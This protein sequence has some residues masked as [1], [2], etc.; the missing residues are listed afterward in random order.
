MI[1]NNFFL[2]LFEPANLFVFDFADARGGGTSLC[3]ISGIWR[4]CKQ[5]FWSKFIFFSFCRI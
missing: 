2:S 1:S 5:L 4:G 3:S